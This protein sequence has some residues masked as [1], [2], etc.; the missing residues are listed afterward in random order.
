MLGTV[1]LPLSIL[2]ELELLAGALV[3]NFDLKKTTINALEKHL[4]IIE[5]RMYDEREKEQEVV[6]QE[7]NKR[8]RLCTTRFDGERGREGIRET[9][10][11]EAEHAKRPN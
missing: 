11:A 2:I 6:L 9:T 4:I 1:S 5:L 3:L 7:R 10:E 8:Q